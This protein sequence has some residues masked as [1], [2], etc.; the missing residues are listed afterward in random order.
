M[1]S[2]L[3]VRI[4][5]AKDG[6]RWHMR[7]RNGRIVA[8]SGEAYTRHVDAQRA[9]HMLVAGVIENVTLLSR[10]IDDAAAVHTRKAVA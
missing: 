8:E 9:A 6:W 3:I 1:R 4:T 7:T 2:R 10:A 5:K